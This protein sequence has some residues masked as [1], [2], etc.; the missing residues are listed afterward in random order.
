MSNEQTMDL[1]AALAEIERLNLE[2]HAAL[3]QIEEL[4]GIGEELKN[5][6]GASTRFRRFIR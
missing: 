2:L 5:C 6:R 1:A 3:H 4:K